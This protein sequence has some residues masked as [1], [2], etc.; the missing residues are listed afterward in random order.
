MCA[1]KIDENARDSTASDNGGSTT[2]ACTRGRRQ[3]VCGRRTTRHGRRHRA[4]AVAPVWYEAIR[5][6]ES[7]YAVVARWPQAP[8]G[9]TIDGRTPSSGRS[10]RQRVRRPPVCHPPLGNTHVRLAD[11]FPL[12]LVLLA[13]RPGSPRPRETPAAA[14]A[15]HPSTVFSVRRF[16][17]LK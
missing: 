2:G 15:A 10:V 5:E 4:D 14:T 12:F 3:R 13:A 11:V 1:R 17:V 8:R 16:P 9:R 7:T 6:P